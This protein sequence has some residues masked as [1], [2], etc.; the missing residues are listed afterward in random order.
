MTKNSF[1]AEVTFKQL[2]LVD[3]E[4]TF[5]WEES[6]KR[7]LHGLANTHV[8]QSIQIS[9]FMTVTMSSRKIYFIL[10]C[11]CC[12]YIFLMKHSLYA[13]PLHFC[14]SSIFVPLLREHGISLIL[15]T[16]TVL[17]CFQRWFFRKLS[18][19]FSPFQVVSYK[20]E[21]TL[22]KE[23]DVLNIKIFHLA[24]RKDNK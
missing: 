20:D 3:W 24:S 14:L 18:G 8:Y 10:S 6:A 17:G 22:L 11:L 13:S 19:S 1:I 16:A 21:W 4:N 7:A 15:F 12:M 9:I 5:N 2:G 23:F